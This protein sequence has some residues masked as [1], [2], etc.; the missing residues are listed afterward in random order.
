MKKI[1]P[2]I[3]LIFTAAAFADDTEIL[4]KEIP[5]GAEKRVEVTLDI[6]YAELYIIPGEPQNILMALIEYNPEKVEPIIDYEEGKIGR[7]HIESKKKS[8][9]NLKD[10]GDNENVWKLGFTDRIP[11]D[12]QLDFGL[13][14]GDLNLS[15]LKL[16][17]VNIDAG[18]SELKIIF[19]K[20]N[21]EK[22]EHFSIDSGLGELEVEGL[23][24]ANFKRF[25]YD[26]GLGSSEL[27]FTGEMKQ[28]AEAEISVGLGSLEIY[29]QEGLPV[30]VYYEKSFLSA[31][32]LEDFR[33]I[34]KGEYVSCNWDD[35]ADV[36][37]ILE[38]EVGL[39][40]ISVEW[41]E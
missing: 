40:V 28:N 36:S 17:D 10:L 18:L 41:I 11:L 5:L 22:I 27:Y 1:L 9:I 13:G 29:L 16:S 25:T 7:L 2:F 39:G 4:K 19:D 20:P 6:G 35:D 32:D 31:V 12:F 37:L 33:Q 38:L 23:L 30:K 14:S 21:P 24:N 34:D 15:G 26:G 8:N 3:L